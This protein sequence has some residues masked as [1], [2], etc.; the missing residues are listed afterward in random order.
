V[1]Q[2]TAGIVENL[3]KKVLAETQRKGF[4]KKSFSLRP[5]RLCEKL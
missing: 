1:L 3:R 4:F 5:L 2:E